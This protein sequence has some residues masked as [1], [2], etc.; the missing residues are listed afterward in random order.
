MRDG[1]FWRDK[2]VIDWPTT[3]ANILTW[4]GPE[5]NISPDEP[6]G[7]SKYGVSLQTYTEFCKKNN[8]PVPTV[9]TIKNLTAD[10]AGYF[11]QV[12]FA[13]EIDFNDLP[14]GVD[15]RLMDI[16]V[17]LGMTGT[18]KLVAAITDQW[19]I[20]NTNNITKY[21]EG[22]DPTK[23]IHDLSTGW[24]SIKSFSLHWPLYGHGWTARNIAQR[25]TALS[26]VK[27]P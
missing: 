8:L 23:L 12:Y 22:I 16:V 19:V 25:N 17:N 20:P 7:I 13:A 15:F 3:I 21:I 6:G 2:M 24:I 11:Y 1:I 4:E 5:V 9:D 27:G 14:A 10:T 26:L 18:N